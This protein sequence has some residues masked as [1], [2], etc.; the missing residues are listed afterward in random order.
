M[1]HRF[2]EPAMTFLTA[3]R[4]ALHRM[5]RRLAGPLA[6]AGACLLAGCAGPG[7]GRVEGAAFK[8]LELAIAHVNDHHSQLE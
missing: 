2:P 4:R 7:A 1:W 6:V 3:P 5:T 8:P